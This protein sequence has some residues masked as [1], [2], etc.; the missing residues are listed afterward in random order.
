MIIDLFHLPEDDLFPHTCG[1]FHT[2]LGSYDAYYFEHLDLLN[3]EHFQPFLCSNL[4]G[5]KVVAIPEQSETHS[6]KKQ[7]FHFEDFRRD[8]WINKQ[9][10][11]GF[12]EDS[13][14]MLIPRGG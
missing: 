6:T 4:D 3:G 5:Y 2:Y 11:L 9:H 12:Q 8:L 13:F 7:Y 10:A 1:C 14:F